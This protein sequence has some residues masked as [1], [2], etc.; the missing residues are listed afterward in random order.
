[1]TNT[2]SRHCERKRSN[3]VYK[4]NVFGM[5]FEFYL[6]DCHAELRSARN[7]EYAINL[8]ILSVESRLNQRSL[9]S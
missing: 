5:F 6:L 4:Y 9:C 2:E 8:V 7:D 1:M 3:P